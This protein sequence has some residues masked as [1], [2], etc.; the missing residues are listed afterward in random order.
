MAVKIDIFNHVIPQKYFDKIVSISPRG[1]DIQKR[2]RAIPS[3]VDL[4]VRFRIMDRFAEYVQA[5]CLGNP[6]IEAL[7]PPPVSGEMAK[8]A[9]DSMAA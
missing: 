5:I 1:K 4:D 8:L 7:G 9:N 3:M 6:P 2:V